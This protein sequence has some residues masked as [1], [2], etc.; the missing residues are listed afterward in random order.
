MKLKKVLSVFLAGTTSISVLSGCS[1]SGQNNKAKTENGK[2]VVSVGLWPDKEADPKNY[3]RMEG[4][5]KDFM[6][7]YP[8]IYIE[9]DNWKFD[10]QSFTAKAEGGTL[11]TL[12]RA[13]F[14]EANRIMELGYAADITDAVKNHGYYDKINEYILGN[15]SRND[16][17]YLIPSEMYT[18]GLVINMNLFR[19]AGLIDE[20]GTPIIPETF[21][22]LRKTASTITQKTG[23]AGFVMPTA[24]NVGGWNF[25]PIAWSYGVHFMEEKD[26]KWT[27]TFA[28]D[29]CAAALK[30]IRDM[31]WEDKSLPLNTKINAEEVMKLI[32]TDQ[33]AMSFAHPGQLNSLVN[34]YAM[35]IN[36]I[37]I[38]KMPA[39]PVKNVT[40]MGGSFYVIEPNATPEQIDAVLKWIEFV[41]VTPE[42]DE[43]G[44]ARLRENYEKKK[45]QGADI[46]GIEDL[47]F[48]NEKATSQAY[49]NEIKEEF[50]NIPKE[51]IASYNDKQNIEFQAE[52]P[53]CAQDL[54]STL[55]RCIQE[56][57]TNEAADCAS[58]LQQ[59]SDD[60]QANFLNYEN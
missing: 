23:K 52:E 17:I 38:A 21:D 12:Y 14:T 20:N 1:G 27:S 60:F 59:A 32:G 3:E 42:L 8:D 41:G 49:K 24:E 22:E 5:R 43:E 13:F 28:S 10:V 58:V 53:V 50:R 48:W 25:M 45:E 30:L 4:M 47:A 57:L 46:I 11:P 29:E 37:G 51:N 6:D 40:L 36:S 33:A 54:Y 2:T 7:K 55:D 31:K 39:G 18:L 19:E 44:K 35:D 16:K 9:P 34:S 26:G 15:I 56:V